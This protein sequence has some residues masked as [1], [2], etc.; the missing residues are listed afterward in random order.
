MQIK[1]GWSWKA[2]YGIVP[3]N[4]TAGSVSG[5]FVIPG[6]HFF[7]VRKKKVG[8]KH[9]DKERSCRIPVEVSIGNAWFPYN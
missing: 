6:I 9:M 1:Q 2:G 7:S 4:N 3:D 8:N 5:I